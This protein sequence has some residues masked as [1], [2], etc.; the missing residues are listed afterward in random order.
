MV[1]PE[2]LQAHVSLHQLFK[3]ELVFAVTC[4]DFKL[5][6]YFLQ[7]LAGDVPWTCD[8]DGHPIINLFVFRK[9]LDLLS[10]D[11]LVVSCHTRNEFYPWGEHL[12]CCHTWIAHEALR[13]NISFRLELLESH[14]AGTGTSYLRYHRHFPSSTRYTHFVPLQVSTYGT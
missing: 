12:L 13:N 14:V 4:R 6:V 3:P 11:E 8:S 7:I 9:V 10:S 5:Q 1:C 2:T